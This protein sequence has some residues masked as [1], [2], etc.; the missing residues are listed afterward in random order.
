[1]K[2][3]FLFTLLLSIQSWAVG[4][5]EI[6]FELSKFVSNQNEHLPSEYALQL[7]QLIEKKTQ[8]DEKAKFDDNSIRNCTDQI[9]ITYMNS[10]TNSSSQSVQEFEA[11]FV[12]IDAS[13]CFPKVSTELVL[14]TSNNLEFRKRS[15]KTIQTTYA[16]GELNCEITDA[17]TIGLSNY[18][19]RMIPKYSENYS[20]LQSYNVW[21]DSD[22]KY[23]SPVFFRSV[24]ESARQIQD[25][26]M[27]HIVSY[28]RANKLSSFQK[29]FAKSFIM[30]SQK[31][32]FKKLK[33]ELN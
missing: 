25:Q 7:T 1:M 3:T 19:Y 28:V 29:L 30:N 21:N 32:V 20:T 10:L 5:D 12:K 9:E 24:F 33:E 15:F 17:P 14:K 6:A 22:L 16:K 23:D 13:L 31:M 2:L 27:Y 18:C 4:T 8:A 11:G 26:T